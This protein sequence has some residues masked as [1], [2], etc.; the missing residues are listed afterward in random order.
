MLRYKYPLVTTT[1]EG[2]KREHLNRVWVRTADQSFSHFGQLRLPLFRLCCRFC[3]L[4]VSLQQ[5]TSKP[6]ASKTSHFT[7]GLADC[8]LPPPTLDIGKWMQQFVSI[9]LHPC[10]MQ[11]NRKPKLIP[12]SKIRCHRDMPPRQQQCHRD[13][14]SATATAAQYHRDS[15]SVPP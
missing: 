12:S 3:K 1:R 13:R 5:R 11:P 8:R 9:R 2:Q 10:M 7:G 14:F 4:P 6:T 15:S